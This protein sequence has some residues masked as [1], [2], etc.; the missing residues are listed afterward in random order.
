MKIIQDTKVK[1]KENKKSFIWAVLILI[2]VLIQS[3]LFSETNAE[4]EARLLNELQEVK[5]RNISYANNEISKL[6]NELEI[7]R[8]KEQSLSNDIYLYQECIWLNTIKDIPTN[9]RDITI[10]LKD[11]LWWEVNK[12]W[13]SQEYKHLIGDTPK[14]R[15]EYLLEWF[16]HTKWTINI[17]LDLWLKYKV[18]PYLAIAIAKADSSLGNQL[19]SENNIWNVG[20]NDRWDTVDY[21]TKEAWIEAIFK[22]L[23]NKY[24]WNIYTIWYLSCWGKTNLWIKDCFQNWEKVYATSDSSWNVNVINTMRNIYRDWSID[25]DY[26][27]R[28]NK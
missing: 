16:T 24:L 21:T 22:V 28:I 4:K 1:V 2:L 27:F 5:I 12:N 11:D 13:V 20:N 6:S 15:A 25:E 8:A 19:K 3:I 18:D 7:V 10:T 23:N 26:N 9:C 17:W 14:A